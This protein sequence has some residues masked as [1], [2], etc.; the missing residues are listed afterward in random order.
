MLSLSASG[1]LLVLRSGTTGQPSWRGEGRRPSWLGVASQRREALKAA[2]T[3]SMDLCL[4]EASG[5]TSFRM[6]PKGH[7]ASPLLLLTQ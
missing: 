4:Q 5:W 2:G 1:D 7:G 3:E 6:E